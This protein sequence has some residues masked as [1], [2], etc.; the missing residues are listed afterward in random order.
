MLPSRSV[1]PTRNSWSPSARSAYSIGDSHGAIGSASSAHSK[2]TPASWAV[3]LKLAS[4]TVVSASGPVRIAVVGAVRSAATVQPMW[5]PMA[6][7]LPKASTA[8]TWSACGPSA[9]PVNSDGIGHGVK[10]LTSS[11]H[12]KVAPASS[13]S[14]AKA[15]VALSVW[16][17]GPKTIVV[18]GGSNSTTDQVTVVI[19]ASGDV[20]RHEHADL[21][22]VR[23]QGQAAVGLGRGARRELAGVEGA[24]EG[25]LAAVGAELEGGAAAVGPRGGPRVDL[26]RRGEDLD[27]PRVPRPGSGRRCRAHRGRGRRSRASRR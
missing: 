6:S 18:S 17:A 16:L 14:K 13:L 26:D 7:T 23:A 1:A 2:V 12:S 8:R 22:G 15:A 25:E 5:R 20:L 11:A 27:V 9:R 10:V 24:L 19:G 21:E 3:K 4:T